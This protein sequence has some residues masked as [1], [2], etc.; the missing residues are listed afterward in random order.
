MFWGMSFRIPPRLQGDIGELSALGWLVR[1]GAKVYLPYGHS[2]DVDLIADLGD[3]L[4]RV[5]VKTST[6]YRNNRFDVTICTRGGNQSWNGIT[7]IS[8]PRDATISSLT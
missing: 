4:L 6:V 1:Q 8:T 3:R 7:S 2:P 5:Q